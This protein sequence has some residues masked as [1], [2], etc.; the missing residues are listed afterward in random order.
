M[1]K[2]GAEKY[3]KKNKRNTIKLVE[4]YNLFGNYSGSHNEG[5]ALVLP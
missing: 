5:E 2:S 3:E 4:K 1:L